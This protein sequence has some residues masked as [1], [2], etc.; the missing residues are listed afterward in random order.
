MSVDQL[1]A[2]LKDPR[3]MIDCTSAP[4]Y[5]DGDCG[6]GFLQADAKVQMALDASPPAVG[7]VTVSGRAGRRQRLVPQ[8]RRADLDRR[9]TR[10]RRR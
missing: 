2:I 8:H 7:A 6:F 3:G 10:T 4:G 5:P 9:R 1:Y